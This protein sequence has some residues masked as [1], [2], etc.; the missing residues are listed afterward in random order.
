MSDIEQI[1]ENHGN[2]NV[3]TDNLLTKLVSEGFNKIEENI[4]RLITKK[5]AENSKEVEQIEANINEALAKNNS[6][7]DKLKSKLDVNSFAAVIKAN[8][9][10]YYY[11]LLSAGRPFSYKNN[12]GK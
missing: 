8:K 3:L 6:Y 5:I 10:D 1:N 9:N 2:N 11:Y 7:A 12:L 4:D